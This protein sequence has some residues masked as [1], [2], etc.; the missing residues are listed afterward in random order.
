[1]EIIDSQRFVYYWVVVFNHPIISNFLLFKYFHSTASLEPEAE[2][3]PVFL[4]KGLPGADALPVDVFRIGV[5][6]G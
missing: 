5:E 6:Y 4:F 3:E 2:L 1:M